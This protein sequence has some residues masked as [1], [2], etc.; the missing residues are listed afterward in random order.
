MTEQLKTFADAC[1]KVYLQIIKISQLEQDKR[2][3]LL[4]Y[5]LDKTEKVMKNQQALIMQL[6]SNEKKRFIAQDNL[7]F[8][9]MSSS[10]ILKM[11]NR[12]DQLFFYPLFDK[13]KLASGELKEINRISL[14]I[15]SSEIR[16]LEQRS[17]SPN[18]LY[19][20]AGKVGRGSF[21]TPSFE[22]H[23]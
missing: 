12:E 2:Q 7:G 9:G 8:S 5:D 15:A 1:E 20:Q 11:L 10:E 13:L 4:K 6:E 3:S 23:I 22:E 17:P 16:I 18:G 21:I 14:D 19:T